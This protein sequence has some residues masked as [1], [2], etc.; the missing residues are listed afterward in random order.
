MKLENIIVEDLTPAQTERENEKF[1]IKLDEATKNIKSAF[2]DTLLSSE[3]TDKR[4]KTIV[5][6]G[7][8]YAHSFYRI[9]RH[10][11]DNIMMLETLVESLEETYQ[12]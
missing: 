6:G 2:K 4:I 1:I 11:Q 7:H 10:L 5:R 9:R 8:Q 12:K 3:E